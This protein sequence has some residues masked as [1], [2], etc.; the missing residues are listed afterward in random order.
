MMHGRKFCFFLLLLFFFH[1][2]ITNLIF[3]E[4]GEKRVNQTNKKSMI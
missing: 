4:R 3:N 2:A 1:L